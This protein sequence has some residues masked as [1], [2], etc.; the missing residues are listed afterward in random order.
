MMLSRGWRYDD[1]CVGVADN[2][3]HAGM[4]VLIR[5]ELFP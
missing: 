4:C 1:K 5:E 3:Y 2:S